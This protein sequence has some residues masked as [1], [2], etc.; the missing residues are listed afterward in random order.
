MGGTYRTAKVWRDWKC[1]YTLE[2]H[3]AAVWAVLALPNDEVITGNQKK[4]LLRV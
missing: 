4:M 3:A 1:I 2:G